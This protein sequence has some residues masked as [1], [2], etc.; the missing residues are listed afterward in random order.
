MSKT[1]VTDKY[2]DTISID[3]ESGSGYIDVTVTE[4]GT[5]A[6]VVLSKSQ[7]ESVGNAALTAAGKTTISADSIPLA[8]S[9]SFNEGVL[10][11]AAIH[12]RTVTFRYQKQ[13]SGFIESRRLNPEKIVG[14]GATLGVAGTDPDRDAPRRYRLERIQGEVS[15]A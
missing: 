8:G 11:I 13:N 1:I 2:G 3:A 4:G 5:E 9:L 6:C 12:K 7:A 15:F 14:Q 10:R